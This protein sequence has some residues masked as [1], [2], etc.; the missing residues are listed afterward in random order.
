MSEA[1][2]DELNAD[3]GTRLIARASEMEWVTSP[4]GGVERKRYHRF[5]PPES[6]QVTSLVRYLPGARFP[7]HPHPEGEEILVLEGTF[8]DARGDWRAGSWLANPEGFEH[9]PWSDEG[10]L[11]FVKLRQYPGARPQAGLDTNGP[12]ARWQ[13]GAQAGEVL[14]LLDDGRFPERITLERFPAGAEL[15]LYAA[16]G[17]EAFLVEGLVEVDGELLDPC[18]F[19]RLPAGEP[20][21]ARVREDA[22]LWI[23]RDGVAALRGR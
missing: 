19:L 16:R 21:R 20:A 1:A 7:N 23:K 6:G 15:A 11:I 9:A 17:L 18:S 10:C 13:R 8:S 14:R 22:L 4:A 5:G 3:L 2:V 12:E